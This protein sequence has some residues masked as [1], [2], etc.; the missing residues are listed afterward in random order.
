MSQSA[1]QSTSGNVS[2]GDDGKANLWTWGIVA[3]AVVVVVVV[4]LLRRKN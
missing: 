2:F 1:S 4:L 3:S